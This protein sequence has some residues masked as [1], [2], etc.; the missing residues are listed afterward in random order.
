M[1]LFFFSHMY[2]I[3]QGIKYMRIKFYVEGTRRRGTVYAEVKEVSTL[4]R[5]ANEIYIYIY[6]YIYMYIYICTY[7]YK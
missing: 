1:F 3:K 4:V 5:F 7:I 2:Y 6:I